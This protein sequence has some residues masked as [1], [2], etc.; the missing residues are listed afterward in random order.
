MR[1][2]RLFPLLLPLSFGLSGCEDVATS[3]DTMEDASATGMVAFRFSAAQVDSLAKQ[4]D[5]L[6]I[7]LDDGKA[8]WTRCTKL[9]TEVEFSDVPAGN[10]KLVVTLRRGGVAKYEGSTLVSIVSGGVTDAK[11]VLSAVSGSL[12]V[13]IGFD[14]GGLPVSRP[15]VLA[16]AWILKTVVQVDTLVTAP[17]LVLEPNG[18]AW[19]NG[20][21][22][23]ERNA[24]WFATDSLLWIDTG[25][26]TTDLMNCKI[27][28]ESFMAMSKVGNLLGKPMRWK[29]GVDTLSLVLS[30][31]KSDTEIAIFAPFTPPGGIKSE[32]KP[33]G[34]WYLSE[35][36]V[37]GAVMDTVPL[38]LSEDGTASG[39]DGCNRWTGK[40][41]SPTDSTIKIAFGTTTRMACLDS[42]G[43]MMEYGYT[44]PLSGEVVWK[45]DR[46]YGGGDVRRLVLSAP[47][48]GTVVGGYSNVP[49][50]TADNPFLP[51]A[52]VSNPAALV[53]VWDL[54]SMPIEGL[55]T[56]TGSTL[57]FDSL[58]RVSGN[59]ACNTASASW[60]LDEDGRLAILGFANTFALCGDSTQMLVERGIHLMTGMPLDWSIDSV[61]TSSNV[62][63]V[64][65]SSSITGAKVAVFT[66]RR[67][68][69]TYDT[70]S[71]DTI[72]VPLMDPGPFIA[73]GLKRTVE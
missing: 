20:L 42:N 70:T 28:R 68:G 17:T 63:L 39:S 25:V 10:W 4:V 6:E 52:R 38:V 26:A 40:W 18:T 1:F 53:G 55:D 37:T 73:P 65:V 62:E 12:R 47:K 41:S 67:F 7:V 24:T 46:L 5:S 23:G 71:P 2:L 44:K 29:V 49:P 60:K 34:T 16:R 57:V 48:T 69:V 66:L 14:E 64:T 22:G 50:G 59:I 32:R 3:P 51:P 33:T 36:P 30:D 72:E 58:G 8:K 31:A 13:E 11:V 15:S 56:V 35:L 43:R 19:I 45:I 61:S 9:S 27:G 54:V 21:C